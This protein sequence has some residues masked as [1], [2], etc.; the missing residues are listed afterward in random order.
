MDNMKTVVTV[1]VTLV[2]LSLVP[3]FRLWY[4]KWKRKKRLGKQYRPLFP[5]AIVKAKKYKQGNYLVECE[6]LFLKNRH[7]ES[8]KIIAKCSREI[9]CTLKEG[10]CVGLRTT[11]IKSSFEEKALS[12]YEVIVV[13]ESSLP[14]QPPV[15]DPQLLL[16]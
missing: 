3:N 13:E 10:Q 14:L 2:A 11:S 8:L 5:A 15:S 7:E 1:V 9:Y 4:L 16:V 12:L 6:S